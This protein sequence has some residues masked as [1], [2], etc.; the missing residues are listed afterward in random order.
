M[1][2]VTKC[3]PETTIRQVQGTVDVEEWGSVL[4]QVDGQDGKKTIRLDETLIVPGITVNLFSLQ[5]VLEMGYLP[6]YGEVVDKCILK[7]K[8]ANGTMTQIATMTIKKGR[9]TLDCEPISSPR[10]SSGPALQ[11]DTFRVELNMQLL[12]RR[13]GHSGIDAMRKLLMGKLVRGI[14]NIKIEDL[15]P[16]EFCKQGKLPQG[17]HPVAH[18]INKGTRVLHLVVVD[19]AGPN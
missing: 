10:R 14:D 13:M 2:N 11:I 1:I 4:L 5:R 8:T 16:C 18:V 3:P 12:H 7:N 6:V 15:Q 17:P 9:A 19:L